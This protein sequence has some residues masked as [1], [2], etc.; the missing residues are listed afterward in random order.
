M[1]RF[2]IE[3]AKVHPL[4]NVPQE[5]RRRTEGKEGVLRASGVL[6]KLE[7][8]LNR[9]LLWV[10]WETLQKIKLVDVGVELTDL[11]AAALVGEKIRLKRR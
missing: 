3:K 6:L 10:D 4:K 7:R 8:R 9:T 1:A 5:F 11:N 2:T